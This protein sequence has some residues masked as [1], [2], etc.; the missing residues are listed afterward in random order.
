LYEG[1]G[2][3]VL[4]AQSSGV[5][6][7]CSNSSSLSEVCDE[8]AI[9]VDPDGYE[10]MAERIFALINERSLRDDIVKKGY[11]NVKRFSWEKCASEI[12][13]VLVGEC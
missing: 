2:I 7:V 3:P 12:A 10:F 9:L 5:P 13:E 1:F 8:S 6:V 11:E 4:E